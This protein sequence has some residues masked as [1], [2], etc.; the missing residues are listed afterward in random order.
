MQKRTAHIL[1]LLL[2]VIF[3][4]SCTPVIGPGLYVPSIGPRMMQPIPQTGNVN[5]LPEDPNFTQSYHKYRKSKADS[6]FGALVRIIEFE[7][8]IADTFFITPRITSGFDEGE[9][10]GLMTIMLDQYELTYEN[11]ETQI[12]EYVEKVSFESTRPVQQS[13]HIH[14]PATTDVIVGPDG[15][16]STVHRAGSVS[17]ANST[18]QEKQ[19]KVESRSQLYNTTQYTFE[20]E[21]I[22]LLLRS[23]TLTYIIHLQNADITIYPTKEQFRIL[24]RMLKKYYE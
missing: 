9:M 17:I 3:A 2:I 10:T 23:N 5:V 15:R 1:F 19:T 14:N 18:V 6:K 8:N 20:A 4:Q 7:Y 22:P 16:H 11:R 24:K 13:Q 21:D 12:R